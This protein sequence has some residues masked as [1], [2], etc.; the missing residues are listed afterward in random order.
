MIRLEN[1]TKVYPDGTK[2]VDDVSFEVKEGNVCVLLGPSGC[3]KTTTMKLINR[4]IPLTGGKIY[5][6]ERDIM[7]MD[8]DQLRT[9][10]G[11]AIQDVG[12]FPHMTV[13]QNIETVPILKGWAREQRQERVD[14]LL[15]LVRMDPLEHRDK[16]PSELSGGQRQR[17]GVARCLGADPE[18]LLMDEPFGAID[19]ITRVE[20]QEEFLK[21][22]H[23]I[24]KTIIFVTHDIY[25]AIRM[26]DMI[27]LMSEGRLVQYDTPSNL[28]Y[29]P[30]TEFVANFV[31]AD[32]ALKA[33]QLIKVRDVMQTT[34]PTTTPDE[35]TAAAREKMEE[36]AINQLIVVDKK[37]A[38]LGYIHRDQIKGGDTISDV[39][40]TSDVATDSDTVLNDAL[41]LMLSTGLSSLAVVDPHN[42]LD[43]ML[44]F[45]VLQKSLM[46][47][48]EGQ[49]KRE[50]AK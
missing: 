31:G 27:A 20:L 32:R 39:M 8:E 1:V 6:N 25:E 18:L 3:G 30:K 11:Y 45:E 10:I 33:L 17:V 19:P 14:H 36:Q 13:A 21:I 15:R 2:A 23:E 28:L 24:Q 35:K 44:R 12:L 22:Q 38:F 26:A 43:G 7:E 49:E 46:E 47:L 50:E 4:L 34:P 9:N 40:V 29:N 5:I 48:S 37:G 16:Y 42:N 41:S